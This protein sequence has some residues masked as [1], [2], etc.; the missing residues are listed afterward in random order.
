MATISMTL[1]SDT[2]QKSRKK[3]GFTQQEVQEMT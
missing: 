2:V 3:L 1:L